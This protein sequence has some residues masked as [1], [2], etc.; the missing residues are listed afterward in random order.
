MLSSVLPT[1]F[2][3]ALLATLTTERYRVQSMDD[4]DIQHLIKQFD[5]AEKSS[6][7][8][9]HDEVSQLQQ[10]AQLST[11][12]VVTPRETLNCTIRQASVHQPDCHDGRTICSCLFQHNMI[13]T[14]SECLQ[15]LGGSKAVNAR[16]ACTQ[17]EAGSGLGGS[18]DVDHLKSS[19]TQPG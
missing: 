16:R 8:V 1:I 18:R 3:A 15:E 10:I 4:Q 19:H 14:R 6:A 12:A 5:F 17:D 7:S 11:P 13:C 2:A 9:S